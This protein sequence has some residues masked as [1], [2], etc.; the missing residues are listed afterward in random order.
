M[1]QQIQR[2]RC[3]FSPRVQ[4]R[5]R[6]SFRWRQLARCENT[7]LTCLVRPKS[8]T[9]TKFASGKTC[10]K[11]IG[12][13]HQFPRLI[14]NPKGVLFGSSGSFSASIFC[15]LPFCFQLMVPETKSVWEQKHPDFIRP[16][17]YLRRVASML[18]ELVFIQHLRRY[19]LP[20]VYSRCR[21]YF[22]QPEPVTGTGTS[23]WG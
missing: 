14:L 22:V 10:P 19:S 12:S 13:S 16:G 1:G 6:N 8:S 5:P 23:C 21:R 4:S 17:D 18:F 15:S 7:A 20:R 11:N 2:G 3:H 9:W